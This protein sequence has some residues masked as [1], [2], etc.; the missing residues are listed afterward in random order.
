MCFID[1]VRLC[2]VCGMKTQ[3]ENI[4]YNT[5]LKFLMEGASFY[6]SYTSS[7][8][9]DN[10]DNEQVCRLS[11]DQKYIRI[12]SNNSNADEMI[13]LS[14]IDNVQ[15]LTCGTDSSGSTTANGLAINYKE[16]DNSLRF[17][18]LIICE[19]DKKAS[20]NWVTA[21]IK[22]FKLM[23]ESRESGCIPSPATPTTP[24]SLKVLVQ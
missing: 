11:N 1:P 6:V 8:P 12:E 9:S 18:K 20:L 10:R 21:M 17:V 7:T 22:A 3:K 24:T 2:N 23:F 14:L 5:H 13:N 15:I 16:A 4:F 19:N